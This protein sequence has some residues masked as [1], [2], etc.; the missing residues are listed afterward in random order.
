[1]DSIPELEQLMGMLRSSLLMDL[2]WVCS[3]DDAPGAESVDFDHSNWLGERSLKGRGWKVAWFRSAFE[4]PSLLDGCCLEIVPSMGGRSQV[5]V[6]GNLV[7]TSGPDRP[8][9]TPALSTGEKAVVAIRN[10]DGWISHENPS[11]ARLRCKRTE[12]L[13][14]TYEQLYFATKLGEADESTAGKVE[15][16]LRAFMGKVDNEALSKGELDSYLRSLEGS[17]EALAGVAELLKSYTI[18]V[19]PHSHV[20]LAWGWTYEETKR[21]MRTVFDRATELMDQHPQYTFAQDQPPAYSH[22]EGTHLM[23]KIAG[24]ISQGRLEPSGA[25]YSEPEGNMPCG[26]SFIRQ[27]MLTKRYFADRFGV[28]VVGGWNLDSFSG[29]CWSLPQILSKSGVRYYTFANW[30]NLIPDVEFWWEG[31][32]GSKVLAYHLPCHYDSAQMMEHHKILNNFFGYVSRSRFKRFLFLDGDDLTP[33]LGASIQGVKWFNGL[34]VAPSVRFSTSREFFHELEKDG[35]DGIPTYRGELVQYLNPAG[36]NNVGSYTTHAEVK[37]RNRVCENLLLAAEK[38]GSIASVMGSVY[39]RLQMNRAWQNVLLN[40]MHDILPGT[41]IK[42]AYE[43]AHRA[44]YEAEIIA[45]DT[46]R[47]AMGKVSSEVDTRGK[48]IPILVFNTLNWRR[49]DLAHL[50]ITLDHSYD[51]WPRVSDDEGKEIQCQVLRDTRGTYDK[52]NR[53]LEILFLA[54]GVPSLGYRVYHLTMDGAA[55]LKEE[56]PEGDGKFFLR[57]EHL[58]AA[59]DSHTGLLASLKVDGKEFISMPKDALAIQEYA[60]D[61]DPWHIRLLGEPEAL[62]SSEGIEV[63]E[64]GPVRKTIRVH[65][66]GGNTRVTQEIYL[67]GGV[68]RLG[69]RTVLDCREMRVLYKVGVPVNVADPTATFEIPFAAMTREAEMDRPAQ[70]WADLSDGDQGL[71]ILNDGRYGYDV[72]DGNRLRLTLLRNPRGH[73]SREG[74][75]TGLHTTSFALFAHSGDWRSGVVRQGLEFNNPLLCH[76]DT[77]H[78]GRLPPHLSFIS[79]EAP[80]AI[81]SCLKP[82]EDSNDLILRIYEPHGEAIDNVAITGSLEWREMEEMDMVERERIGLLD[83]SGVFP[84]APYEIRTLRLK[85]ARIKAAP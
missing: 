72:Q 70:N 43:E 80:N 46:M 53:N 65:R 20:D 9:S 14:S 30:A 29:H 12:S 61:G 38:L 2:T 13:L 64:R 48:G 19:V 1:M 37:R 22:L 33:P 4:L 35:L 56:I 77:S 68:P 54:D 51:A 66:K 59:I 52:T 34:A 63:V 74:T 79:L 45:R 82:N 10:E 40:Q 31:P 60:D 11:P 21:I 62:T 84:L 32:D 24:Y 71:A 8:V 26:E 49:T 42:E 58:V 5:F 27:I 28:D 44:Y 78:D 57:N 16:C 76:V 25:L 39:P 18:Y 36:G 41:A 47:L 67:V 85:D 75:D 81:T 73:H 83:A 17:L 55:P 23:E 3:D 7:G 15:E 6:N 50:T 69:C